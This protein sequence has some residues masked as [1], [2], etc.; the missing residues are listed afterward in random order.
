[1]GAISLAFVTYLLSGAPVGAAPDMVY[2]TRA[3]AIELFTPSEVVAAGGGSSGGGN[4]P[5]PPADGEFTLV[6][7]DGTVSWLGAAEVLERDLYDEFRSGTGLQGT[8]VTIKRFSAGDEAV[9]LGTISPV[10]AVKA[11][12]TGGL[13]DTAPVADAAAAAAGSGLTASRHDHVHPQF[14]LPYSSAIPKPL[15]TAAAGTANAISRGDHVH[16]KQSASDILPSPAAL[17]DNTV[18]GVK[19]KAWTT[20]APSDVVGA[21]LGGYPNSTQDGRFLR[22]NIQSGSKVYSWQ[23]AGGGSITYGRSTAAVVPGAQTGSG[24]TSSAVS[25]AD[26]VHKAPVYPQPETALPQPLGPPVQG[27]SARYSRGDH[28][29]QKPPA[30]LPGV[31]GN[32][33]SVLSVKTDASGVEWVSPTTV[34]LEG[35]G[36][37]AADKGKFI[38]ANAAG[39][40]IAL[41]DP[42]T[43][44]LAGLPAIT[45][46]GGKALTVNAAAT[47]V[48]WKGGS[49]GGG[50]SA[51]FGAL[52]QRLIFNRSAAGYAWSAPTGTLSWNYPDGF[53]FADVGAVTAIGLSILLQGGTPPTFRVATDGTPVAVRTSASE[54]AIT[55]G[56]NLGRLVV[57]PI[58]E[59]TTLRGQFTIKFEAAKISVTFS[60]GGS[61]P[62]TLT[63]ARTTLHLTEGNVTGGGGGS[64][65]SIPAP[66]AAGKLKH[67]RVNAAGGAYELAEPPPDVGDDV[68][69]AERSIE[70]LNA[71]TTD[72]IAGSPP[73]GWSN[74]STIAQGGLAV[75][76]TFPDENDAR[77]AS[78]AVTLTSGVADKFFA[79]R[80]PT[81]TAQGQARVAIV[82]T[83]DSAGETFYQGANGLQ[84]IGASADG[85]FTYYGGGALGDSV[86]SIAAQLTSAAHVGSSKFAG[87]PTQVARWAITGAAAATKMPAA[88]LA[89]GNDGDVLVTKS[90]AAAWAEPTADAFGAGWV[91]LYDGSKQLSGGA[92][93]DFDLPDGSGAAILAAQRDTEG[94]GV[95]R[96]FLVQF[97]W[98]IGTGA[99]EE[100]V[101]SQAYLPGVPLG[102]SVAQANQGVRY[103]GTLAGLSTQCPIL[104]KAS[105]SAAAL[106]GNGSCAPDWGNQG[107]TNPTIFWKLWGKR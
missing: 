102:G 25:R 7:A 1:M 10:N 23:P 105:T 50:G 95:Y 37:A 34:I 68:E 78:W 104:L 85:S 66:T 99:S 4:V 91:K 63:L 100:L 74:A 44:L 21:A 36:I 70:H 24:G 67:L 47:G 97:A 29:H 54:T 52:Y 51:E 106:I 20:R 28:V 45:G 62:D 96:Q 31:A 94:A 75:F 93:I 81:A 26:H 30:E 60:Q 57:T 17:A 19:L 55:F 77:G 90:G 6:A 103:I 73:A 107:N 87:D 86:G 22:L 92:Q 76:S 71:I 9:E 8:I 33:K 101:Q 35:A 56:G 38:A 79:L 49:S 64:N 3:G 43:A 84:R 48:E 59:L 69:A 72:L 11:G 89:N 98:N 27:A 65:P 18:L 83:G 42:H 40:G 41:L 15:G 16:A 32:A 12:I 13:S 61:F 2:G 46:Q 80:L 53:T 82:G 39:N 88:R 14:T 5:T 58:T